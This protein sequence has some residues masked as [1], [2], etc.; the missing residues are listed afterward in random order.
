MKW[1][2]IKRSSVPADERIPRGAIV[3]VVVGLLATV[4]AALLTGGSSSGEFAHLEY[5][6]QRQIPD[7]K[8]ATVPGS[9]AKMQLVDGKIQA[10]GS[11][12]ARYE[13]FRVLTTL[14]I[15]EGAPLDGGTLVCS[16]HA[17]RRNTEIAHSS[18]ELRMTYPRS[19][20][21]G[22]YGQPIE[23]TVLAQFAS[24][25]HLYAVLEVAY[26]MPPRYT[27]IQGVKLEWPKFEEG[28]EN[29]RYLLPEGKAKATVELPFFTI[30]RARNKAPAA[31]VSC[32]LKTPS[33]KA[34][35]KT[36]GSIPHVSPA[37]NEE[38]EELKREEREE[39]EGE[40]A[41]GEEAEEGA[42]GE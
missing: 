11:N 40:S 12:V 36:E 32:T 20:E 5:V 18:G 2:S 24:H 4:A 1:P 30:W 3:V 31:Q 16:T 23:E 17:P 10:T 25:G 27:T 39:N 33:G 7:S 34:T 41:E 35:T 29:L 8:P 14:K 42:E 9:D 6:Q 28:T 21:S 13:L 37:I 19:S 22:I 38:A 15:D 26:D